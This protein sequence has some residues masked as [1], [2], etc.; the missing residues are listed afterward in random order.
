[1]LEKV[2]S[3]T[4]EEINI[5][6]PN[7]FP[8]FLL[9]LVVCLIGETF[10]TTGVTFRD[11][12]FLFSFSLN[13]VAVLDVFAP[14]LPFLSTIGVL[15]VTKGV[16]TPVGFIDCVPSEVSENPDGVVNGDFCARWAFV[17]E[18]VVVTFKSKESIIMFIIR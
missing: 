2:T 18:D 9:T 5:L 12:L 10:R 3:N 11:M 16:D 4:N 17:V 7:R 15:V 6:L 14:P 8:S 13:F 1:M